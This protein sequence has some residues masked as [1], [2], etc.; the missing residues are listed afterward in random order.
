MRGHALR[1]IALAAALGAGL[2]V[3]AVSQLGNLFQV[4]A[5]TFYAAGRM[6]LD[7]LDPYGPQFA[8]YAAAH[9]L[10]PQFV[11]VYPPQWWLIATG[12]ACLAPHHAFLA[13]KAA[14]LVLLGGAAILAWL[15]A[16]GPGRPVPPAAA[17][18]FLLFACFS[19]AALAGFDLG[20][21]NVLVLFGFAAMMFGL[22]RGNAA[23][24]GL[25]LT[26]LL[27]K[28]QFGLIFAAVALSRRELRRPAM[29]A[30]AATG[31]LCLPLIVVSGLGGFAESMERLLANLSVYPTL[32]WNRPLELAGL[33]FVAALSGGPEL[34]AL[35]Y[36]ALAIGSCLLALRRHGPIED[37]WIATVAAAVFVLP[38]HGYDFLLAGTL[39]LLIRHL[40]RWAA[41]CLCL[42]LGLVFR[43]INFALLIGAGPVP[44]EQVWPS[45]I[46]YMA[47]YTLAGLL[48]FVAGLSGRT[49]YGA[50]VDLPDGGHDPVRR[51]P[52]DHVTVPL[53]P[54]KAALRQ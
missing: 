3:L 22:R 7:G 53:Q 45:T 12:L 16:N 11:W 21:T 30:L 39:L 50:L 24:S 15:A 27:L 18:A 52:M 2:L 31:L 29:L 32:K 4:D 6:W 28:P 14:N 25:G 42:A 9:G 47:S 33:D 36:V 35:L 5:T 13:W 10:P 51:D 20:Q 38:L 44:Y 17:I 49:S 48:I 40:R 41:V 23:I 1:P 54:V 37:V 19:D 8:A 46:A 43:P 34:S 26:L